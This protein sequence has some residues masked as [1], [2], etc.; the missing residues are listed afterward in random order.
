MFNWLIFKVTR[1]SDFDIYHAVTMFN[2]P[3]KEA[4]NQYTCGGS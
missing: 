3:E 4:D 1:K 2:F